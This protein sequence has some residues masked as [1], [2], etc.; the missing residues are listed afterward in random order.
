MSS[1][2]EQ[3]TAI[4]V[5]G[6]SDG[7][8]RGVVPDGWQQG[9]G[10]FGGVAVGLLARAIVASESDRT[11]TLRSLAADLCAPLLPGAVELHVSTLRRGGSV[12]F[13]DARLTQGGLV[14]AHASAS[15]A[16]ARPVTPAPMRPPAPQR[17]PWR[18]I[19][20]LP[21]QPP[22]GPVFAAKYEYRSTGPL[23]FCGGT[24]AI[25]EGW[26]RER[27]AP[28]VVDEAVIAGMLDAWWPTTLAV[29]S[30]PRPVATVGYTMQLLVDPRGLSPNEPLFYRGRG[31]VGS[32]NYFVEMRELWA[33]E[34][35]VAMN[36][37]TFALLG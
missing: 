28:S 10:A 31:V 18:D 16:S 15:L 8:F 32:D 13:F 12:S 4:S 29:E 23:P 3:A 6:E 20:P 22:L 25:A 7:M 17:P 9:K 34:S 33:G 11:R 35:V 27:S 14:V 19:A 37:Q 1:E 21:V 5:V 2:F 24:E 36:Q 30:G 26:I